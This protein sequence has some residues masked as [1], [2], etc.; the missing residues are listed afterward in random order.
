MQNR[1]F[2]HTDNAK[3]AAHAELVVARLVNTLGVERSELA[4]ATT[5]EARRA[6]VEATLPCPLG[7][8]F[9]AVEVLVAKLAA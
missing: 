6:A 1:R 3:F 7:R 5:V 2:L 4:T 9:A 8:D